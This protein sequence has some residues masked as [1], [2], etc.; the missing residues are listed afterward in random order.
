[1]S[2]W[3]RER[4]WINEGSEKSHGQTGGSVAF[5]RSQVIQTCF[6]KNYAQSQLITTAIEE[7]LDMHSFFEEPYSEVFRV[8]I[9]F[10]YCREK[11]AN[12]GWH[13][14]IVSHKASLSEE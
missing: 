5:W 14:K 1:M 9:T 11:N 10:A 12:E 6:E 3:R 13:L 7:H 8:H 2:G 4:G